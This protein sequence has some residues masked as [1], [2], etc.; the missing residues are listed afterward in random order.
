MGIKFLLSASLQCSLC[1]LKNN[2]VCHLII[3]DPS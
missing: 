1:L 3:H 2:Q